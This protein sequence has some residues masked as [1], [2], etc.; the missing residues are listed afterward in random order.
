MQLTL[1]RPPANWTAPTL[2]EAPA[3]SADTEGE[4]PAWKDTEM[5]EV[6]WLTRWLYG[7]DSTSNL[8]KI[9]RAIGIP[10]AGSDTMKKRR[11]EATLRD[12]DFASFG[13]FVPT[14]F[15]ARRELNDF[16]QRFNEKSIKPH[17]IGTVQKRLQD[18]AAAQ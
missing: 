1:W 2:P 4:L 9:C 17:T 15:D 3:A 6:I 12:R 10:A 13:G 8:E 16:N 5:F 7:G 14:D 18:F 11:I